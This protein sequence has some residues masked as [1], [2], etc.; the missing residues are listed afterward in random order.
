MKLRMIEES[1]L[2][3]PVSIYKQQQVEQQ[4]QPQSRSNLGLEQSAGLQNK[5]KPV[6]KKNSK[7]KA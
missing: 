1:K 7:H 5:A 6:E 4:K 2:S 3:V